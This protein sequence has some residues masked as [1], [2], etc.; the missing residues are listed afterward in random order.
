MHALI[1]AGQHGM[2]YEVPAIQDLR[3]RSSHRQLAA[4]DIRDPLSRQALAAQEGLTAGQLDRLWRAEL[5]LTTTQY[6]DCQRLTYA[7]GQLRRHDIPIKV[8]AAELGFRHLSQFSNWFHSRH[9]ESPRS[10][11]KRPGTS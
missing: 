8:I 6:H 1:L 4:M 2:R 7:C 11:R 10:F 3:V 5:G 9:G